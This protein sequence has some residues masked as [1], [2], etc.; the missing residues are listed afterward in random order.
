[1]A[2]FG[3]RSTQEL[4]TCHPK[5]QQIMREVIKTY[6]F[7]V[8]HGYRDKK[9]QNKFYRLGT[10]LKYPHSLHNNSPSLAIDI[11]PWK[12]GGIN[13]E[14]DQEFIILAGK[15]LEKSQELNIKVIWGGLWL[16]KDLGHIGLAKTEYKKQEVINE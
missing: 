9:L 3:T 10:G 15:I 16:R 12:N 2:S 5:L 6:D 7:S 4:G 13:W 1:M 14:D 8:I 11:A